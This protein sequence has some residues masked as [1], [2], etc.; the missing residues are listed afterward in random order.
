MM[1]NSN[2]ATPLVGVVMGSKS[3][4]QLMQPALDMLKDLDIAYDLQRQLKSHV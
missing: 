3:D 4:E 2:Q 1:S